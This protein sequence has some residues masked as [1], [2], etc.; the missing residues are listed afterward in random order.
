MRRMFEL[1][2]KPPGENVFTKVQAVVPL[3]IPSDKSDF[4]IQFEV[5]TDSNVV[6]M[7][8]WS[9]AVA[10]ELMEKIRTNELSVKIEAVER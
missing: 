10:K 5:D 8:C 1:T 3:T 7:T 2:D 9:A 6:T 4:T